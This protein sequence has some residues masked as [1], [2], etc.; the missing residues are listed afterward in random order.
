MLYDHPFKWNI[1][2]PDA[3]PGDRLGI[4]QMKQMPFGTLKEDPR[5]VLVFLPPAGHHFYD[6]CD[7]EEA[8]N[9][10]EQISEL[11]EKLR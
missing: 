7:P 8:Q 4:Q 2:G 9:I 5:G 6:G 3:K 1:D 10:L 11:M